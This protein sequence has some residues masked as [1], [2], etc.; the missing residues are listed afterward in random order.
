[1]NYDLAV[2]IGG[3]QASNPGKTGSALASFIY[4]KT[5]GASGDI[6]YRMEGNSVVYE[7][8]IRDGSKMIHDITVRE[9]QVEVKRHEA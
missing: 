6:K 7:F 1:M 9:D 8:Q 5:A 3:L 4:E 2:H